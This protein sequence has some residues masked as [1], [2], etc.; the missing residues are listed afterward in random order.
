MK[1][2][3]TILVVCIVCTFDIA[4]SMRIGEINKKSIEVSIFEL[5]GNPR[6]FDNIYVSTFCFL[7]H[8]D[9][10]HLSAVPSADRIKYPDRL[11]SINLDTTLI[12]DELNDHLKL[13]LNGS[14]VLLEGKFRISG[15]HLEGSKSEMKILL[16][17]RILVFSSL[18][19]TDE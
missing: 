17:N 12:D 1:R 14:F 7:S 18:L 13:N 8:S 4:Y 19:K 5:V 9:D 10:G 11:S 15:S 3:I 6:N 16:V 2:C